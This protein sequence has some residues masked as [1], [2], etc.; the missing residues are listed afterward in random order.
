M[1]AFTD[2]CLSFDALQLEKVLT[3]C[4][5]V[6]HCRDCF[7]VLQ[8][9]PFRQ[10]LLPRCLLVVAVSLGIKTRL[11]QCDLVVFMST[12]GTVLSICVR[13]HC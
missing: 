10:F 1:N 4:L 13:L 9:H 6:R 7:F 2:L 5:S 8:N 3:R 12:I 11:K